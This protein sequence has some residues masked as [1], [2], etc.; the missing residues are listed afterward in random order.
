MGR[1][2]PAGTGLSLYRKLGIKVETGEIALPDAEADQNYEN[3]DEK[4]LDITEAS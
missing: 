3:N 2:I 1:L 4:K